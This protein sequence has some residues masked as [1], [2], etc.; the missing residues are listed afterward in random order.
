MSKEEYAQMHYLLGKLKYMLAEI[1][2][3]SDSTITKNLELIDKIDDIC[4]LC[5]IDDGKG[6]NFIIKKD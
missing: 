1:S 5:I 3:G 6:R 2:L 4:R